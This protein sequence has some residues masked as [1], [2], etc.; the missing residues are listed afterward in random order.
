PLILS[1]GMAHMSEIEAAVTTARQAGATDLALL[2]CTSLYPAPPATLNLAAMATLAARFEIPVGHS[3]HCDGP[4]ACIAA[5]AAGAKLIEKHF[6][7]DAGRPGADH[8][9]SLEPG[10]FAAMVAEIR[11]VETML[12]SAQKAPT[13]DEAPLRSGRHRRLAARRDIAVGETL[14]PRD[15]ALMRL[16]PEV[17]GLEACNLDAVLGRRTVRPIARHAGIVPEDIEGSL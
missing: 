9:I 7:M 6:T 16:L 4:L 14:E 12:G 1:T 3:D 11:I 2:Q 13:A 17:R 10:P 8:H 15:I 5:V